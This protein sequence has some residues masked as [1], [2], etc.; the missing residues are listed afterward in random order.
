[1]QTEKNTRLTF[2]HFVWNV[3]RVESALLVVLTVLWRWTTWHT[4]ASYGFALFS[5]GGILVAMGL[6]GLAGRGSSDDMKLVEAE[7][8]MRSWNRKGQRR[9]TSSYAESTR[10]MRWLIGIGLLTAVLGIVLN[11]FFP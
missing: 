2:A 3:L 1:M 9:F 6:F 7:M 5:A 4:I 11:P 8:E 10:I